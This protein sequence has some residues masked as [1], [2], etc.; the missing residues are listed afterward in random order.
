MEIDRFDAS[1]LANDRDTSAFFTETRV[2]SF[3]S[4]QNMASPGMG[5]K[6]VR[7]LRVTHPSLIQ[8]HPRPTKTTPT[9]LPPHSPKKRENPPPFPLPDDH[10][11]VNNHPPTRPPF[12]KNQI[13]PFL[14]PPPPIFL[15]SSPP[16]TSS[17]SQPKKPFP[18]FFGKKKGPPPRAPPPLSPARPFTKQ[19]QVMLPPQRRP[20][21]Q[22]MTP[23]IKMFVHRIHRA[24]RARADAGQ[25]C[26]DRG[27]ACH[28]R[29]RA[30]RSGCRIWRRGRRGGRDWQPV[31]ERVGHRL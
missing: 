17:R 27:R 2:P 13:S 8:P 5:F 15:P 24:G 14:P 21:T 16:H 11:D 18:F 29:R 22:A 19:E 28:R 12:S 20:N 30:R 23:H 6:P 31:V 7:P 25:Q 10:H 1:F 9:R 26:A 4:N 3:I